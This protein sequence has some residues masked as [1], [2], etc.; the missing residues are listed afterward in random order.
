MRCAIALAVAL[1]CSFSAL[2]SEPPADA[3]ENILA[4]RLD[5]KEVIETAIIKQSPDG[6]I[7]LDVADWKTMKGVDL[8]LDG[9]AGLVSARELGLEPVFDEAAQAVNLTVPANKR[10]DQVLGRQRVRLT[11]A[12][13]QPK[14]ALINYDLAARVHQDGRY[15]ASLG[16]EARIGVGPAT[17]ITMGQLNHTAQGTE[18]RRSL[19]TLHYDHLK[20]GTAVQVGDVFTPRTNLST[21]VNLGG[22]RIGSDRGLRRDQNFLPVP[23]L[24]GVVQNQSTAEIFVNG[25][26]A[27]AHSIKPGPWQ[28]NEYPVLPGTNEVRVVVRDDFGREEILEDRFYMAPG[29]LPKGTTEWE[30]V[31]G[32]QRESG[33][34]YGQAAVAAKIDRGVS[35][36]WTAGASLQATQDAKNLVVSNRFTLG[37]AG[38]LS[39]DAGASLTQQGSGSA[40]ALSYDYKAKDWSVHAGHT[41]YSEN[42]WSLGRNIGGA[43]DR[44]LVSST[45]AAVSF[46]PKGKPWSAALGAVSLDYAD[47][48]SRQRVDASMRYRTRDD[49]FGVGVAYHS[50]EKD[51]HVYATWRRSF[52]SGTSLSAT[53]RKAPEIET[54]ARLS[55][56]SMVGDREVQWA[57]GI[58]QGKRGLTAWGQAALGTGKGQLSVA[59]T[60]APQNSQINARFAGSVWVGEGGVALQGPSPG[61]FLVVEVEGQKGVPVSAG[62]GYRNTTNRFGV[63][64]V[65]NVQPLVAHQ[66]SIDGEDMPMDVGLETTQQ[67][68]VAGRRAGGKV[69]FKVL[70]EKMVELVIKHNG[71]SIEAPG[72]VVSDSETVMVGHGGSV[73]LMNPTPGQAL[74]VE[75]GKG[76]TCKATLPATLPGYETIVELDCKE[77]K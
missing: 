41:R 50:Q 68:A 46:Q 23:T 58:E 21:N 48:T 61:A 26:R 9:K 59:G 30:V 53:A 7:W 45:A 28:V 16:H 65:P 40:L 77:D 70:S 4:V 33:N 35:K 15:A 20:S 34:D 43:D 5:G 13:P 57:T 10:P 73:V 44:R 52:G 55:G 47:G 69:E 56:R 8:D 66:V 6:D 63:A 14:G 64:V 27:S 72:R 1:A 3:I 12:N 18:Y 2:A 74:S 32:L 71:R 60:Y 11:K 51:P 54:Q 37:R 42:Y 75:Y 39:I 49:E 31:A 19:T 36:H 62:G 67:V 24:G 17:L 22:V 25:Q 29:N 76:Q 38:A